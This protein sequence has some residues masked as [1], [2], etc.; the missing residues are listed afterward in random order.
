MSSD[1]AGDFKLITAML[2]MECDALGVMDGLRR[3][4]GIVATDL[5][6]GRGASHL[7]VQGFG[8]RIG[9]V[10]EKK[11]LTVVVSAHQ[12]D[13]AFAYV[14]DETDMARPHGGIVYQQPL[15]RSTVYELP[16]VP[17]EER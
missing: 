2:P 3:E 13:E 14:Y 17:L 7:T 4:L 15:L 9:G 12:A 8:R 5:H 16:E 6:L 1:S 10:T 11:V